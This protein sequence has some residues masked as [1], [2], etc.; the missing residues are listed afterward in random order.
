MINHHIKLK[1]KYM[2][3]WIRTKITTRTLKHI[4][5]FLSGFLLLSV[6]PASGQIT[7][8]NVERKMSFTFGVTPGIGFEID[9]KLSDNRYMGFGIG[10][11]SIGYF[12]QIYTRKELVANKSMFSITPCAGFVFIPTFFYDNNASGVIWMGVIPTWD[13]FGPY[14]KYRSIGI[15][16]G[17]GFF[18]GSG[19]EA[20]KLIPIIGLR[21]RAGGWKGTV[22]KKNDL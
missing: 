14:K 17:A 20:S 13:K 21:Y 18:F 8:I 15:G 12:Q 4:V 3:C 19:N 9:Y 11:L 16:P 5:L 6:G 22:V 2:L 1:V 10:P 7:P